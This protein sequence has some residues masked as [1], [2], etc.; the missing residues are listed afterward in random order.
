[1][2]RR[3]TAY[4]SGENLKE[5]SNQSRRD[6][7]IAKI[8]MICAIGKQRDFATVLFRSWESAM[9]EVE[10]DRLLDTVR[11]AV[12]PV[13]DEDS[14]ALITHKPLLVGGVPSA[15]NDNQMAWPL[16][17]FPDGWYASC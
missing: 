13:P 11:A 6:R 17:P 7:R 3:R 1:L 12:A 5:I 8:R 14:R 10:F 16:I 9:S 15:A 2:L 4:F